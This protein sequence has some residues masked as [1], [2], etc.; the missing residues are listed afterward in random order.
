MDTGEL[1]AVTHRFDIFYSRKITEVAQR[2]G[3]TKAEADVLLF[4]YNNPGYDTARDIVEIR[5]IAK[6]Y[7]SKAVELLIQK[8]CLAAEEDGKDRRVVRLRLLPGA[9]GIIKEGRAAQECVTDA[10]R[11]GI[12][13]SDLKVFEKVLKQMCGNIKEELGDTL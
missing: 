6:S 4:L 1:L 11:R 2:Y 3:M 7:V 13:E 5:H 10:V 12:E 8:E 9:S